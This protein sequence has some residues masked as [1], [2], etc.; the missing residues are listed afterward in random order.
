MHDAVERVLRHRQHP[1]HR[2]PAG[3]EA[4]ERRVD[5]VAYRAVRAAHDRLHVADRAEKVAAVDRETAAEA[6][7]EV[8]REVRH[9]DHLMGHDLT[10]RHHEIPAVKQQLVHLDRDR[11]RHQS[12]RE[13]GDLVGADL[14]DPHQAFP[15]AVL[16][17]PVEGNAISEEQLRFARRH[18]SVRAESGQHRNIAARGGQPFEQQAGDL[19]GPRV[20]PG[21]VGRNEQH[22]P[23]GQ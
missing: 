7:H 9:P 4:V 6:D 16:Q 14:A 22:P 12:R 20:Q 10:D 21:E 17:D 11:L 8:L 18:R 3:K 1:E 13:G 15:P 5:H 2:D 23:R 19:P